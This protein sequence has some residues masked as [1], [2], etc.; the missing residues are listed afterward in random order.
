MNLADL[1]DK[2]FDEN[3]Y[4][5]DRLPVFDETIKYV[6][7]VLSIYN[8]HRIPYKLS[9]DGFSPDEYIIYTDERYSNEDENMSKNRGSVDD[10]MHSCWFVIRYIRFLMIRYPA[11]NLIKDCLK[12]GWEETH[13]DD[14]DALTADEAITELESIIQEIRRKDKFAKEFIKTKLEPLY[15]YFD[16]PPIDPFK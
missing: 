10:V 4:I 14:P 6:S 16:I 11:D 15:G 9:F 2:I 13:H 7:V 12:I 1:S 8:P 5:Q 3:E